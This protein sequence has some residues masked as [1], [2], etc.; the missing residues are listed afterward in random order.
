MSADHG[1]PRIAGR[2][3]PGISLVVPAYNESRRIVANLECILAAV[4]A[5]PYDVELVV[6]DDGSSDDTAAQVEQLVQRD[7]R[8]RLLVFTRNFGK[9]AALFAGLEHARGDAVVVLDADLQHPPGLIPRMVHEWASGARVVEAVKHKRR[10]ASWLDAW[11]A[12]AFYSLYHLLSGFDIDGHSDFKL[13]DREI[14]DI[15]LKLPER[16]RFF[17]GLVNWLG[18]ESQVIVFDIVPRA[19]GGSRWSRFDL[20]RYAINNVTAF[21]TIPLAI[22]AWMGGATLAGGM[23]LGLLTLWQK[24]SGM[25]ATGFTTVNILLVLFGGAIM[26]SLGI[27]GHYIGKIYHEIKSRPIYVCKPARRTRQ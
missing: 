25:S 8:V 5:V 20:L 14:V 1:D 22:V 3:R 17:R 12:T 11:L 27:I 15:Y 16:Y 23:V 19:S 21:S 13:L 4:V 6:V 7:P 2:A 26:T 18:V 9:E 10:D 24:I